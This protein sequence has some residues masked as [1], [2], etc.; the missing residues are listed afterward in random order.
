MLW[1]GQTTQNVIGLEGKDVVKRIGNFMEECK[2]EMRKRKKRGKSQGGRKWRDSKGG[3]T[4]EEVG[5]KRSTL[6]S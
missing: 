2:E 4:R 6:S 1:K 5:R 3:N